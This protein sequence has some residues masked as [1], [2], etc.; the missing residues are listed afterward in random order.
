MLISSIIRLPAIIPIRFTVIFR[1]EAWKFSQSLCN[2]LKLIIQSILL[3]LAR[4]CGQ[5]TAKLSLKYVLSNKQLIT[6]LTRISICLCLVVTTSI[7]HWPV[8]TSDLFFASLFSPNEFISRH[9]IYHL[10]RS[11]PDRKTPLQQKRFPK[12]FLLIIT[13]YK[14]FRPVFVGLQKL[15]L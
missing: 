14:I 13:A 5:I 1:F 12:L 6:T 10:P 15:A 7:W 2:L 8:P 11:L 9:F 3:F 4:S